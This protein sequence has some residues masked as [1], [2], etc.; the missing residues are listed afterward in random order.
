[1]TDTAK[2]KKI[3]SKIQTFTMPKRLEGR[4]INIRKKGMAIF[5]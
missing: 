2:F 1:M 3:A 4:L 5:F